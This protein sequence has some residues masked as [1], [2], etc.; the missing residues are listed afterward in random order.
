[1]LKNVVS[2]NAKDVT[3]DEFNKLMQEK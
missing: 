1:V 3:L 2:L